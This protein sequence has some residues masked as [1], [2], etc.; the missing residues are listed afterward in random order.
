MTASVTAP[1]G[2][3]AQEALAQA[4]HC[5]RP[6]GPAMGMRWPSSERTMQAPRDDGAVVAARPLRT[7]AAS[8][9]SACTA[10]AVG[11]PGHG[12]IGRSHQQAG[13]DGLLAREQGGCRL[14]MRRGRARRRRARSGSIEQRRPSARCRRPWARA[15]GASIAAHRRQRTELEPSTASR[16]ADR[17]ARDGAWTWVL[18]TGRDRQSSPR[19]AATGSDP[20]PLSRGRTVPRRTAAHAPHRPRHAPPPAAPHRH[21]EWSTYRRRRTCT[22]A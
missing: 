1:H 3:P 20:M 22:N 2:A 11:Q 21:P 19:R 9:L 10:D 7:R 5:R 4:V 6:I 13:L 16:T 15:P 8:C 18:P 17:R 14:R 12:R